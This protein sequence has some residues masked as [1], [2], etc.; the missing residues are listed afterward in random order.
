[1][2]QWGLSRQKKQ[3][4]LVVSDVS[5]QRIGSTFKGGEVFLTRL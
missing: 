4:I 2:A 5:G 3:R 1:M